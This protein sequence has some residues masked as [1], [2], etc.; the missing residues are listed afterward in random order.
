MT[1]LNHFLINFGEL[2]DELLRFVLGQFDV[3]SDQ[4]LENT[5][6]FFDHYLVNLEHFV[7]NFDQFFGQFLIN[8]WR[9][10]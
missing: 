4:F 7:V 2:F 3:N 10:I 9:I 6:S 8:F 1:I 5:K